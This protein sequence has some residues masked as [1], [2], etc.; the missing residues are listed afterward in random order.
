VFD[1]EKS[2]EKIMEKIPLS[3]MWRMRMRSI[4]WLKKLL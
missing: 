1:E 3:Y 4:R 2:L